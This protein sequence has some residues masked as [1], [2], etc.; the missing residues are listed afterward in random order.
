MPMLLVGDGVLTQRLLLDWGKSLHV[1]RDNQFCYS[2]G[3][4]LGTP[5]SANI[6]D[7]LQASLLLPRDA[8]R[9]LSWPGAV[10]N[11]AS[12][13]VHRD[14]TPSAVKWRAVASDIGASGTRGHSAASKSYS[15]LRPQSCQAI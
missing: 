2:A 7:A 11:I 13:P 14:V 4:S 1:S 8:A 3:S 12:P 5:H 15:A 10:V 6:M 9:E